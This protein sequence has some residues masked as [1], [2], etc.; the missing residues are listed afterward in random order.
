M[1]DKIK[2]GTE[3]PKYVFIFKL[4]SKMNIGLSMSSNMS[5]IV[6]GKLLTHIH[7]CIKHD[8]KDI[9]FYYMASYGNIILLTHI[10][11]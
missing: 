10:R 4:N 9:P 7:H 2:T 3:N 1:E 11:K 8:N 6:S 5:F